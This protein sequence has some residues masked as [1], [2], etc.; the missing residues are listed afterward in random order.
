MLRVARRHLTSFWLGLGLALS[1]LLMQQA[2]LRHSLEHTLGDDTKQVAHTTLCKDCLF[3][4]AANAVP[5]SAPTWQP[6]PHQTEQFDSITP[7]TRVVPLE[8]AY[9][10]RAPPV[11]TA[12]RPGTQV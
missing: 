5:H 1:M 2:G 7:I 12:V 4:A 6:P 11:A 3:Y 8:V 10:P 9:S